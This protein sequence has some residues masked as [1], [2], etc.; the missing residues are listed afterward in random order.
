MKKIT[1]EIQNECLYKVLKEEKKRNRDSWTTFFLR[2]K[3]DAMIKKGIYGFM[4]PCEYLEKGDLVRLNLPQNEIYSELAEI[5]KAPSAYDQLKYYDS[6]D[7]IVRLKS[8][9]IEF[10][11]TIRHLEKVKTNE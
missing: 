3:G 5:V 9:G 10:A 1:I 2:E 11:T 4:S 7:F 6:L 8:N